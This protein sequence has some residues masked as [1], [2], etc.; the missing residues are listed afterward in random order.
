MQERPILTQ[1]FE[2][3]AVDLV[4]P[5]PKA[6]GGYRFIL[7]SICLASKWPDA[8]PL[9]S[10][11]AK[12]VAEGLIDIFARTG[13]PMSILTD[14]GSQFNCRLHKELC[15]ILAI[16]HLRTSTYYPQTNRFVE[17]MHST[18]EAMLTNA[19]S[20]GVSWV[21]QLLFALFALRQM[22]NREIGFSPYD[23]VFGCQ[24]RTPLD[25]VCIGWKDEAYGTIESDRLE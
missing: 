18:L 24:V 25:L 4:G 20:Q 19:S 1:P 23:L 17:Q 7:T 21:Q 10:I 11:T 8:I 14:Q 9:K 2:F 13:L 22:P 16:R 3:I 12:A 5:L 6:K 15:D